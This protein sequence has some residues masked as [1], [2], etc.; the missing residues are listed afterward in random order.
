M[1]LDS[2]AIGKRIKQYRT[3]KQL[4]QEDLGNVI[5]VTRKHLSKIEI[6]ERAPTLDLLILIANALDVSSDDLLVGNLTHSSS[7]VGKEL[8]AILQ[9]CNPYQKEMLIRVMKFLKEL[10]QEFNI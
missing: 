5:G 2:R 6:G 9:D 1:A 10:F 4:S 8:H 3:Q 7:S